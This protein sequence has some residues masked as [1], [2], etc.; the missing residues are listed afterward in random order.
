M[1]TTT[2]AFAV[3]FVYGVIEFLKAGAKA[4]GLLANDDQRDFAVRSLAIL[5][6][7]GVAIGLQLDALHADAPTMAGMIITGVSLAILSDVLQ[8]GTDRV[9]ARTAQLNAPPSATTTSVH[10][11]ATTKTTTP[12]QAAPPAATYSV[13]NTVSANP[14]PRV[15]PLPPQ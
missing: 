2:L 7:I 11:D 3:S 15:V 9:Q 1:N 5:I 14:Q 8:I 12:E 13:N 4:Y 10:L 6:G